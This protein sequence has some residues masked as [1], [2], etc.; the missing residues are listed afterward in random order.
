MPQ[1]KREY[2]ERNVSNIK[3][4]IYDRSILNENDIEM[5][6]LIVALNM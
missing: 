6:K 5:L 2:V 3:K 1:S 4:N